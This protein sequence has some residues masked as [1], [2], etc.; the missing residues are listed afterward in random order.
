MSVRYLIPDLVIE[1][2][3]Q[4]GLYVNETS[5]IEEKEKLK[6]IKILG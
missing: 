4:H 3:K 2:I 1:Y 5:S 6:G